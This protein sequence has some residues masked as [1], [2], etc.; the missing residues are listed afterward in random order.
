MLKQQTY[1]TYELLKILWDKFNDEGIDEI[2]KKLDVDGD[3]KGTWQG[4]QPTKLEPATTAIIEQHTTKFLEHDNKFTAI[5]TKFLDNAISPDDFIG[6]DLQKIQLAINYAITNHKAI[7]FARMYDV[8]GLGTIVINKPSS[9]REILYLLGDGGG[10][11]KTDIGYIFQGLTVD[12]GDIISTKMKYEGIATIKTTVWDCNKLIRITSD[13]DSYKNIQTVFE[14]D[15]RWLQSIRMSHCTVTG[16]YGWL[17][18]AR[19]TF[20]CNFSNN[21][22]EQRDSFMRNTYNGVFTFNYENSGLRVVDNCI[23]GLA[24]DSGAKG[25]ALWLG[26]SLNTKIDGN[27]MEFCD[28]DYIVLN[29]NPNNIPHRGLRVSNNH[30]IMNETQKTNQQACIKWGFID[31]DAVSISNYT[32][33]VL[34]YLT[35]ANGKLITQGD[36]SE[37]NLITN[38][39]SKLIDLSYKT[40]TNANGT[41]KTHGALIIQTT[42]GI[43][44]ASVAPNTEITVTIPFPQ[45]IVTPALID[46]YVDGTDNSFKRD[47]SAYRYIAGNGSIY[48]N[49]KN[50][51]TIAQSFTV[52]AT[53]IHSKF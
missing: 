26:A 5:D 17:V 20:D 27:Y 4:Y 38:D 18:S 49:L 8:T 39:P 21:T 44:T 9:N 15:G 3:L 51:S 25:T 33:G 22:I 28:G 45:P 48:I 43:P 14:A 6:N 23:E 52:Y 40:T 47:I 34:H 29:N 36:I 11:K 2:N 37:P 53:A 35:S 10:I 7:K 42:K 31:K 32:D 41:V 50:T 30:F 19:H 46:F 16:G 13:G 24:I 12:M 1:S